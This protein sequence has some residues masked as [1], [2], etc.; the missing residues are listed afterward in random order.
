MEKKGFAPSVIS[1]ERPEPMS[2]M[3]TGLRRCDEGGDA[4]NAAGSE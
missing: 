2:E 4:T 3:R 1:A